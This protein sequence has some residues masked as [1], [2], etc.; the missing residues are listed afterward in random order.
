MDDD[1]SIA[2][3]LGR[4]FDAAAM[5]YLARAG[6]GA[7]DWAKAQEIDRRSRDQV[8]ALNDAYQREHAERVASTQR[9]LLE[10]STHRR[11]DHPAPRGIGTQRVTNVQEEAKRLVRL[12]HEDDLARVR[13]STREE[14]DELLERALAQKQ[15]PS[16]LRNAFARASEGQNLTK[17]DGPKQTLD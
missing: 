16:T 9:R 10:E 15:S 12:S 6:A 3:E 7:D 14:M 4:T 2:S 5:G 13:N 11:V 17:K 1:Q 8:D